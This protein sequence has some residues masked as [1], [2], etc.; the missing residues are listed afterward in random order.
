M[1]R[2]SYDEDIH[3]DCQESRAWGAVRSK[4]NKRAL[5]LQIN[6]ILRLNY[7]V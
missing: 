2:I 3:V 4:V 1:R 6:A 5:S 7:L